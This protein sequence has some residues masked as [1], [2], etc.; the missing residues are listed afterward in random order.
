MLDALCHQVRYKTA[1]NAQFKVFEPIEYHYDVCEAILLWER[2]QLPKAVTCP[3]P[4]KLGIN[5]INHHFKSEFLDKRTLFQKANSHSKIV[6]FAPLQKDQSNVC[7]TSGVKA[8]DLRKSDIVHSSNKVQEKFFRFGSKYPL[9]KEMRKST[10]WQPPKIH[11]AHTGPAEE[12]D[13]PVMPR[14]T[15]TVH[16]QKSSE[17]MASH[18]ALAAPPQAPIIAAAASKEIHASNTSEMPPDPNIHLSESN[19]APVSSDE[20]LS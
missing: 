11:Q 15:P 20:S 10:R 2:G 14:V 16:T 19:I 18:D 5:H 3:V 9:S 13:S 7:S 1:Y 4:K 8:Y 17:P 6:K 12:F